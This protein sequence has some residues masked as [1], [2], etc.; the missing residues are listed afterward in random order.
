[1]LELS[2]ALTHSMDQPAL[3]VGF[4]DIHL[5][6][7]SLRARH[8]TCVMK[9]ALFGLL[10]SVLFLVLFLMSA[11][12]IQLCAVL[13]EL[14]MLVNSSSSHMLS[15]LKLVCVLLPVSNG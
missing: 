12:S 1:M 8:V 10:M 15:G 3:C 14:H 2:T 11:T 5:F 4:M 7:A 9:T 6:G 13:N